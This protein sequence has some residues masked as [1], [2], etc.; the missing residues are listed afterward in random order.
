MSR[1][2]VFFQ[3]F[4]GAGTGDRQPRRGHARDA[5]GARR[6]RLPAIIFPLVH[7]PVCVPPVSR[8]VSRR[9]T[10]LSP[11]NIIKIFIFI[12]IWDTGTRIYDVLDVAIPS[13]GVWLYYTLSNT[14]LTRFSVSRCHAFE[15]IMFFGGTP[16]VHRIDVYR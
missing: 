4:F 11:Y 9:K 6:R 10:E 3:R 2:A 16:E 15:S 5:F 12:Y 7:V 14:L 8:L 1:L 13:I